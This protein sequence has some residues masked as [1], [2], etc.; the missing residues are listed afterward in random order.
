MR[1]RSEVGPEVDREALAHVACEK[2]SLESAIVAS[3]PFLS[4]EVSFRFL[5]FTGIVKSSASLSS[6][7]ES[8]SSI[9][10]RRHTQ[11]LGRH[12]LMSGSG[13]YL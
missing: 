9:S 11:K 7:S 4:R 10:S 8:S 12:Q 6:S 3:S 5:D 1:G 13:M 2:I